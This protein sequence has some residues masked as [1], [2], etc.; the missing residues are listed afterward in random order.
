LGSRLGDKKKRWQRWT[1]ILAAS[2][3]VGVSLVLSRAPTG[4]GS[5]QSRDCAR[6]CRWPLEIQRYALGNLLP[7]VDQLMMGFTIMPAFDSLLTND[8]AANLSV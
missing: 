2:W 4:A 6:I 7:E 3:L 1:A 5:A 8:Q